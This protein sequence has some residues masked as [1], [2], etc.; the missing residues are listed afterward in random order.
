MKHTIEIENKPK[1]YQIA[2]LV[3]G[4]L[5]WVLIVMLDIHLET[6]IK[7]CSI[8]ESKHVLKPLFEN[9]LPL[10][11]DPYGLVIILPAI[12]GL[13]EYLIISILFYCSDLICINS[14]LSLITYYLSIV[15]K[16]IIFT[17]IIGIVIFISYI[18]STIP[19]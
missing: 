15:L 9:F 19:Y 14:D 17:P 6:I 7:N 16:I 8:N 13:I 5:I 12:F 2:L 11:A 1:T 4:F 18:I 10:Q 3:I